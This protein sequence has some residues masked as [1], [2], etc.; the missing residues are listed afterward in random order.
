MML[1]GCNTVSGAGQ[2]IS[3]GCSAVTN[4]AEKA[5]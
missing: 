1:A 2:D 3:A 4:F 5:K